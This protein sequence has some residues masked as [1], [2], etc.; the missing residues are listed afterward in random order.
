LLKKCLPN[1]YCGDNTLMVFDVTSPKNP[2]MAVIT[3]IK[4]SLFIFALPF[5]LAGCTPN[6]KAPENKIIRR[7]N[8]DI[9]YHIYGDGGAT[10]LFVHGSYANQ[11]YW[12][13]Q[14]KYFSPDYKVVTMDLPGH[15]ESGKER[16]YWTVSGFAGDVYSI[17]KRLNLKNVILIGH[18]LGGDI[19]LIEA[20]AHP[21][22]I[23]GFIGIDNFKNAAMPIPTQYQKQADQ[24]LSDLK[25]NF[26]GT[27][28]KYVRIALVTP[29]TPQPVTDRV[30]T[31]FRNGYMPMGQEITPQVFDL[32]KTEKRLLPQLK[33][34]LHLI[35]VDYTP[36]NEKPLKKYARG[37]YDVK[38]MK[39]TSHYPMLEN[40]QELNRLLRVTIEQISRENDE[41]S[42]R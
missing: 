17:I 20:T 5:V 25:K 32:Y 15:G 13:E 34:K 14:V 7:D 28:E 11:T 29:E 23:I 18:S 41:V 26:S 1:P 3:K 16:K 21:K 30:I 38:H 9:S 39:G 27:N 35:N 37:G 31:D 6:A 4:K 36:T 24:I 19:N 22:N 42:M 40:P 8:A 12:D 10:L 2:R 33:L